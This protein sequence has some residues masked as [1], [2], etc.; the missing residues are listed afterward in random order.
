MRPWTV[1]LFEEHGSEI[2]WVLLSS[3]FSREDL[4]DRMGTR[5]VAGF[6]QKP[7]RLASL[8]ELLKDVGV[9]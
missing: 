5:A 4:A 3:G 7:Y 8:K 2:S 1:A 6:M 9:A